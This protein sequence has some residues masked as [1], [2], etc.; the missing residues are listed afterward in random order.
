MYMP[1]VAVAKAAVYNG[2]G[3]AKGGVELPDLLFA[4]SR[5]I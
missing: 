3:G 4:A 1:S 5:C 2:G